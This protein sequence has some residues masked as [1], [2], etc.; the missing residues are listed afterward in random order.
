MITIIG[1][2]IGGVNTKGVILRYH[3]GQILDFKAAHQYFEIWKN[4]TALISIL[5]SIKEELISKNFKTPDA[6]A[7]TMTAELSDVFRTKREGVKFI[8]NG[9]QKAFPEIPLY[10]LDIEGNLVN[11]REVK[12]PLSLAAT[13]WMATALLLSKW[14]KNCLLLD[15]GSTT[16]DIIPIVDGSISARGKTDMTRL[17]S[18][19]LVYTGVLRTPISSIVSQVPL[20]GEFCRVSAEYFAILGDVHLFLGNIADS[21][22]TCETP[23]KRP[24]T[25]QFAGERLAR[26]VCA[27][28]EMLEEEEITKVAYY[29]YEKQIQQITEAVLQILSRIPTAYN[30]LAIPCGL[31]EFM[32][33]IC[34]ER[35]RLKVKG[36]GE[37]LEPQVSRV[38][39][40][41]A[42]AYLLGEK[43]TED[44]SQ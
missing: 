25:K 21:D 27:D 16:T 35:L 6:M 43:L 36:M 39:P 44:R 14:Y 22:Y 19:E 29:I 18:G 10:S 2:D 32:G 31:G 28:R 8:L 5:G 20:K 40:C 30:L 7:L 17:M 1:W 42:V 26:V 37:I 15:I 34:C 33:K 23:D 3:K 38:A 12:D 4:Q 41:I 11:S 9:I 13:N 24:K